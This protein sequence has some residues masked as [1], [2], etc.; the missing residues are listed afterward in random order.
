MKFITIAE[1]CQHYRI[2]PR[3]VWNWVRSGR[4]TVVRDS[5]GRILRLIDPQ[6]PLLDRSDDPD[7]VKRFAF[8]KPGQVAALLGVLPA[9]VRKMAATGRIRSVRVGSQRRFSLS[10]VRVAIAERALGHKP[11]NSRETS[12]GVVRWARWKLNLPDPPETP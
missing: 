4:L 2:S 10:A 5:G 11:R 1:F 6:W 8:L 12:E 3:T 9:T 7:L